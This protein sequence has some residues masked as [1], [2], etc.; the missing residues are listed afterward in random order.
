MFENL[1]EF[2]QLNEEEKKAAL[3]I[4]QEISVKGSSDTLNNYMYSDYDEVPVTIHDFMHNKKYLG[5][6]LYDPE[7]RFTVFPY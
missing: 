1:Q 5:N 7:G 2:E 4:L 6:A 3:K